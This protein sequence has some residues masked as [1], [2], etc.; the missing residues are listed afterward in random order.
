MNQLQVETTIMA[1]FLLTNMAFR[2]TALSKEAN[3]VVDERAKYPGLPV[4]DPLWQHKRR[5][6]KATWIVEG[7]NPGLQVPE[8]INL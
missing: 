1:F 4:P 6:T 7:K 3:L 8:T 2:P 5:L